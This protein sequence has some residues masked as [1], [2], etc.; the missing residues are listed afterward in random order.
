MREKGCDYYL[1]ELAT[2][3]SPGSSDQQD[4]RY[5]RISYIRGNEFNTCSNEVIQLQ[6]PMESQQGLISLVDSKPK[7]PTIITIN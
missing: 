5:Q 7:I 6:I 3:V 4:P 2:S 1:Y